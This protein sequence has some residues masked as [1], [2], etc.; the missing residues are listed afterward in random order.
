M[1]HEPDDGGVD[2]YKATMLAYC[3]TFQDAARAMIFAE[4]YSATVGRFRGAAS[5]LFTDHAE[6]GM[7]R[8]IYSRWRHPRLR[9]HCPTPRSEAVTMMRAC[10]S[11]QTR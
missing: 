9:G 4:P 1:H 5:R 3:S 8:S 11:P 7:R 2:A 6:G 10:C